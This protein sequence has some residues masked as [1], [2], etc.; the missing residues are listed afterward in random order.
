MFQDSRDANESP[1]EASENVPL[2][3]NLLVAVKLDDDTTVKQP[4]AAAEQLDA[5]DAGRRTLLIGSASEGRVH[6]SNDSREANEPPNDTSKS[7]SQDHNFFT[8]V[9]LDDAAAVTELAA[10]GEE[11]DTTDPS[12]RTPLIV[13]AS[14]GRAAALKALIDAGANVKA[15][16]GQ[17]ANATPPLMATQNG[18]LSCLRLLIAAKAEVSAADSAG[19]TPVCVAAER[20]DAECL[21]ELLAADVDIHATSETPV[22]KASCFGHTECL[23]LLIEANADVNRPN[24]YGSTAFLIATVNGFTDCLKLLVEAK[25]DT[26]TLAGIEYLES[27]KSGRML[28]HS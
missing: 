18:H 22:F 6:A 15:R 4:A 2:V 1:N 23:K 11:L 24:E 7:V 27:I 13:A 25:A 16:D 21:K 19:I 20:G 14:E 17:N 10:A 12:G 8:A 5:M 9:K 28:K 26:R 3:H